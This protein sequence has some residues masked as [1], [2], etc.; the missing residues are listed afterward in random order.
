MKK[1]KKKTNQIITTHDDE[2][3]NELSFISRIMIEVTPDLFQ[4]E[5]PAICSLIE[6]DFFWLIRWSFMRTDYSFDFVEN[7]FC[8]AFELAN[9]LQ[10]RP[11]GYVK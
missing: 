5:I 8:V 6:D 1:R 4:W 11:Y 7:I 9:A 3:W 10:S 2:K